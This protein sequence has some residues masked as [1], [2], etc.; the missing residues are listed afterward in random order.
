MSDAMPPEPA[1]AEPTPPEAAPPDPEPEGEWQRLDPRNLLL[2]P[3]R[4]LGQFAVPALIAFVGISSGSGGVPWWALPFIVVGAVV[5]GVLPWLT[6]T[7]RV[8]ES[9]LQRRSGVISRR[10]STAPLA[11]IRSVD[12]EASL[13]HRV[14]G[15]AKVQIGTGV[16]DDRITLDAIDRARAESLRAE[17]LARRAQA[18]APTISDPD[19]GVTEQS[20]GL[21]TDSPRD[22]SITPGPHPD[23]AHPHDVRRPLPAAPAAPPEELARINWSWLR[24]AP[25]SLARLVVFAG[26]GGVLSQLGGDI[27]GLEPEQVTS[28]WERVRDIAVVVLGLVLVVGGLAIWTL[29]AVAGYVI[30]WWGLRLTRGDGSLHLTA[31]L[32][33]TRS[34]SV[35]ER[36]IR[37]VERVEPVLMRL[38]RGAELSTLATGVGSGGVTTIL[39]PSPVGVA[40]DVA[41]RVLGQPGVLTTALTSHGPAAR[42]RCHTRTQRWAAVVG[43][44]LV[45]GWLV[46]V[47]PGWVPLVGWLVAAALAVGA[48]E[49]AYSHLGHALTADHLVVG[50]GALARVRTA[51]E[52]DG[53]IGWG[54]RQGLW[55][56]RLGLAHLVATTAAGAEKVVVR[57]VPR[58][59]ALAL[60][61]AA[62][63]GV[64]DEFVVVS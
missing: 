49:A 12:L 5:F 19:I 60:A 54:V 15:L 3:V 61:H 64:L 16:D 47:L 2:D 27:P 58:D 25:F 23:D 59:R 57:D 31:G 30:Q 39:P 51:L 20:R 10:T 34:I 55:Q 14:L 35:E 53:I 50:S 38:L 36:R 29:V 22:W 6:T 28:A 1:A 46:W 8:T 17:L 40:T 44:P 32:F 9:H 52:T 48:A 18:V 37:G 7:W 13:L 41:D 11:R 26:V 4:T 63:P 24:F 56:R 45:V 21:D 33:T 43:V 62:T 42:R